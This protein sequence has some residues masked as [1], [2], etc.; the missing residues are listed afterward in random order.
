MLKILYCLLLLVPD[1]PPAL[2][3]FVLKLNALLVTL[4]LGPVVPGIEYAANILPLSPPL[5]LT[6]SNGLLLL[7][8]APRG[9][10][11]DC[12]WENCSP[13]LLLL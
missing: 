11:G 12:F 5:T 8:P 1:P 6:L 2:P 9:P 7:G 4:G 10:L 13:L 3:I